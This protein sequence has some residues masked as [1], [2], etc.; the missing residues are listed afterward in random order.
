MKIYARSADLRDRA[1]RNIIGKDL[2]IR[3]VMVNGLPT[4]VKILS[5]T[6][7]YYYIIIMYAY[8]NGDYARLKL[9]NKDNEF[10][11][12]VM[13]SNLKVTSDVITEDDLI[14][15]LDMTNPK[16]YSLARSY[17]GKYYWQWDGE[18]PHDYVQYDMPI[19]MI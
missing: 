10:T 13:K 15:E 12:M 2:W 19:G 1:I 16:G 7:K 8:D 11:Q 14:D 17:N 3:S 9:Q 4:W 6:S 5:E 18:R